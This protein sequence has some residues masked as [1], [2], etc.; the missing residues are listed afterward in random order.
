[1][2]T[3]K[4]SRVFCAS[5]ADVFEDNSALDAEREKL[6]RLIETTPM[7]DWLL[8]TKRPENM[9]RMTPWKKWPENVWAMTSVENQKE[10]ESRIPILLDVPAS[11]LALSVEP[12]IGPVDL[13]RWIDKIDWVIVGGESGKNARP[14]E[15]EWVRRVRDQSLASNTAFFF[16]QWGRWLPSPVQDTQLVAKPYNY[17]PVGKRA[18]GRLLD[19]ITWDVFPDLSL[20]SITNP[21]MQVA[22]IDGYR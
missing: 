10:A 9:T 12:L 19:G 15:I 18:A 5:M 21:L 16:K 22:Q 2:K 1:M 20:R 11:I 14:M 6:W 3:G 7:L 4:R 8:L 13:K 17:R